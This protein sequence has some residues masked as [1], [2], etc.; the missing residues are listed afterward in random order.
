MGIY[1]LV[2]LATAVYAS[3]VG[4]W[5]GRRHQRRIDSEQLDRF[6]RITRLPE[7]RTEN[8]PSNVSEPPSRVVTGRYRRNRRFGR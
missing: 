3:L 2:V 1:V 8:G 4:Y 5:L 7:R 6:E